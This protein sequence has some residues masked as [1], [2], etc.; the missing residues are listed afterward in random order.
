MTGPAHEIG[1]TEATFPHI[2]LSTTKG[3]HWLQSGFLCIG[4]HE[5][6]VFRFVHATVV[7]GE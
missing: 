1:Y 7:A 2:M 3:P 6:G 5:V 4:L